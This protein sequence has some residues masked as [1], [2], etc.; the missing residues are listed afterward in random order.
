MYREV[1]GALQ[2]AI[3]VSCPVRRA[4]DLLTTAEGLLSWFAVKAEFVSEMG[5]ELQLDIGDRYGG[6]VEGRIKGYD[7]G[8]GIAYTYTD[9]AVKRAYGVTIARWAW[10]PLSPDYTLLTLTH[11]GHSQGDAWQKAFE[12][13]LRSWSFYLRNLVSVVNEGKDQREPPAT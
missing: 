8:S 9:Y 5:A 2:F 13:H 10:E 11:T 7:Q 4:R 6:V 1:P 12:L 3:T